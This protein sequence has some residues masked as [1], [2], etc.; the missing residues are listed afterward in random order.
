MYF[1][2][3]YL[4]LENVEASIIIIYICLFSSNI[5]PFLNAYLYKLDILDLE[6]IYPLMKDC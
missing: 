1:F 3:F 5:Q 6:Q 2:K 4:I